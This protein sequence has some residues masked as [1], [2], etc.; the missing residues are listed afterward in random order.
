[1]DFFY[2]CNIMRLSRS[3]ALL[4]VSLLLAGCL[5]GWS[6]HRLEQARQLEQESAQIQA[7]LDTVVYRNFRQ[8]DALLQFSLADTEVAPNVCV[9]LMYIGTDT[10]CLGAT[11]FGYVGLAWQHPEVDHLYFR[12]DS[13][14]WT[15]SE[16]VISRD[17]QYRWQ[18]LAPHQ[19]YPCTDSVAGKPYPLHFKVRFLAPNGQ[20]LTLSGSKTFAL[21]AKP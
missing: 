2:I 3:S 6:W 19:M 9:H 4:V 14:T 12:Q 5:A 7:F 17:I 21:Q 16:G 1:M 20:M 8:D 18:G 11:Q 15:C 10:A 13:A